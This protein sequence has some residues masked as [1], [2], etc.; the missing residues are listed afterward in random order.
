MKVPTGICPLYWQMSVNMWADASQRADSCVTQY[1]RMSFGP[2]HAPAPP[3]RRQGEDHDMTIAQIATLL[4]EPR[5]RYVG[6]HRA[7]EATRLVTM[8]AAPRTLVSAVAST[9]TAPTPATAD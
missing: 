9:P 5:A 8:A 7:P 4:L 1:G 2:V 6:R 3:G